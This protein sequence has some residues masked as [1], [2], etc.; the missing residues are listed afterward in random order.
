[1]T[2]WNKK[3]NVKVEIITIDPVGNGEFCYLCMDAQLNTYVLHRKDFCTVDDHE[4]EEEMKRR[5]EYE[6]RCEKALD[7]F[8]RYNDPGVL[9]TY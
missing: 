3:N 7:D 2:V 9:P 1:M 5:R 8:Q 4:Y 6:A